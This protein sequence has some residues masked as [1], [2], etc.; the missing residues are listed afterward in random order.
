V[1]RGVTL[2]LLV[3]VIQCGL[4]AVVF[5]P[6]HVE[7]VESAHEV[8]TPFPVTSVDELRI[9]DEFDNE[10]VLVKSGERWLLPELENLPA[11]PAKVEA[12]LQALQIAPDSWPI[13]QSAAARQRFQVADYYYQRRITLLSGGKKLGTVYLGTSPGFQKVHARNAN[14]GDIYSIA[15]STFDVPAINSAWLEPRLL[16]VRAPLRIDADLYN[17]YFENGKWLS[18]TGGTPD[19][20]EL[21][22]LIAALKDLQV[23]GVA[24]EDLQRDL[25]T[26]EADLVLDVQSLAGEVTLQLVT[27]GGKHYIQSSEFPLFFQLNARDYKRLAGVDAGLVAGETPGE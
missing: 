1:T 25:S 24:N 5:W 10:A 19:G 12:A 21:D 4:V 6:Q 16:Q 14:E 20:K 17:L 26:V 8:L 9:G 7:T 27:L 2:L 11:D 15:L 13:A 18:R 23:D 3:L 22:A